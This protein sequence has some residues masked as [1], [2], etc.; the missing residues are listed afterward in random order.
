[1]TP[2][3]GL[4][5]GLIPAILAIGV[6][7]AAG[8]VVLSTLPPSVDQ[9]TLRPWLIS[10]GLVVGV[11]LFVLAVV[12]GSD[13]LVG[14]SGIAFAV[15]AV[16]ALNRPDG[17]VWGLT[18]TVGLLWFGACEL[19]W[20]SILSR[21]GVERTPA[22]GRRRLQEVATVVLATVVVT[23]IGLVVATQAP[24]RSATVK[25]TVAAVVVIALAMAGRQLARGA[26]EQKTPVAG[27]ERARSPR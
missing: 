26:D 19:A 20:W 3:F 10:R 13:R 14:V 11:V 24:A 4:R 9:E 8:L 22:V 2:T 21:D 25:G 6:A 12:I 23:A 18:M 15:G 1:M 17:Q 27:G 7:A 16:V 5:S